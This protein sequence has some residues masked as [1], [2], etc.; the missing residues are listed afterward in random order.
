MLITDVATVEETAPRGINEISY[1]SSLEK[2]V[3]DVIKFPSEGE[4]AETPPT[5]ETVMLPSFLVLANVTPAAALPQFTE[6]EMLA[7]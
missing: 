6:P 1:N 7:V 5:K 3:N 2:S 4:S